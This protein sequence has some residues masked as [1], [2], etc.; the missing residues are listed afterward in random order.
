MSER[1]PMGKWRKR[2][3]SE[4]EVDFDRPT[5][6]ARTAWPSSAGDTLSLEDLV[7]VK[8]WG[9]PDFGGKLAALLW[10]VR[11]QY[12]AAVE[13]LLLSSGSV[14][15]AERSLLPGATRI[16]TPDLYALL[17]CSRRVRLGMIAAVEARRCTI[18]SV[19]Q[20]F[21]LGSPKAVKVD[22]ENEVLQDELETMVDICGDLRQKYAVS[23]SMAMQSL[24]PRFADVDC[25]KAA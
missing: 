18:A 14:S 22:D 8:P 25:C 6:D 16:V 11:L 10:G 15:S 17:R 4:E 9:P 23:W 19:P 3:L 12:S 1:L 20:S 21:S 5:K 13:Y 24:R 2:S 7:I